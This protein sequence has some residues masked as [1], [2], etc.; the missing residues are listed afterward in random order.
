MVDENQKHGCEVSGASWK[1]EMEFC[2]FDAVEVS[3]IC[4]YWWSD[5]VCMVGTSLMA[6]MEFDENAF[7]SEKLEI[8]DYGAKGRGFCAI[9]PVKVI[10]VDSVVLLF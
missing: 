3:K 9:K 7:V 8:V 1:N 6:T 10:M 4:D 2:G 5:C